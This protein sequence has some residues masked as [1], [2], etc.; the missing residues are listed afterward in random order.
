M[1]RNSASR[2]LV[3]SIL[4]TGL[5]LSSCSYNQFGAVATGSSLGGMLGSSIGGLMGGP[6]GADCDTIAGMVIGGAVGLL[7]L[8]HAFNTK[9]PILIRNRLIQTMLIV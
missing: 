4:C 7:L 5:I 1:K 3:L 8:P 2:G 9:V 6:R